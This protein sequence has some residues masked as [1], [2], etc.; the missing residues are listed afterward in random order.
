MPGQVVYDAA[1]FTLRCGVSIEA[2]LEPDAPLGPELRERA[3][4]RHGPVQLSSQ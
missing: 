2:P 1:Y 3:T 4:P